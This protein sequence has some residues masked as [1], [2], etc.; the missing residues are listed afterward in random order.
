M[1]NPEIYNIIFIKEPKNVLNEVKHIISTIDPELDYSI[2]EEA[3]TD[4]VKLFRGEYS[5]Y[6]ACNTRYHDLDHTI[7]VFL[8]T[9]RL[10]HGV[11]LTGRSFSK[12]NIVLGLIA[13]LFH[14]AG[15][16]QTEDDTTGTGAKYT[17]G[18][19]ERSIEF[20]K[21]Y[22]KDKGYKKDDIN[23]CANIILCTILEISPSDIQFRNN[24]VE[25]LG[26]IVG[27]ADI[28]AQIADR[29]YLEKLLY[30]YEEFEEARI[31]GFD[32]E[33]E[34]LKKTE[35]FYK[36]LSKKRMDEE[37]GGIASVMR[38][39]FKNRLGIDKDLYQEYINKNIEYLKSILEI[40]EDEYR[41]MLRR[42]GI[43]RSLKEY[44]K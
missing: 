39:H 28:L 4:T 21:N 42:G 7:A 41:Q 18:H 34:L 12:R 10:I 26:K 30:L 37:L 44:N 25:L 29:I 24:G 11:F 36:G 38:I 3:F 2:V 20:A 40:H 16:I 23:D 15:F 13:A 1:F 31:P 27:T 33:I 14:D 19:E 32:S 6:R 43:V 9:G 8:A 17:I 5:G 35:T 22:L